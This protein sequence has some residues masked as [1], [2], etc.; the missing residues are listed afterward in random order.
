MPSALTHASVTRLIRSLQN[1]RDS[2]AGHLFELYFERLVKLARKRLQS[3]PNLSAY[4]EDVALQSFHSLCRRI[5][6]ADRPL[7]LSDRDDLWRL[8]AMRTV[9]RAIDVIRHHK[10]G[11]SP[12][13]FDVE[14]LLAREPTAEEAAEMADECRRLLDLL[15]EP[16]LRQVALWKVEGYTHEEIAAKLDCLPRTVE[17]KVHR[18]RI[19]WKDELQGLAP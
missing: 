17:R 13:E 4:D 5:R 12:N 10:P 15:Q 2:A 11:E 6:H 7:Q 8:L 19:L 9:S 1:G 14:T 16:E 3:M 18:I